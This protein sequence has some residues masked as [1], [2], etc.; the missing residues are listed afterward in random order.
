[1][2]DGMS[3]VKLLVHL[4]D[5]IK[6]NKPE[7]E[8]DDSSITD[9]SEENSEHEDLPSSEGEAPTVKSTLVESSDDEDDE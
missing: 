8:K 7:S 6:E 4:A 5:K 3:F 1:M 9:S 2:H